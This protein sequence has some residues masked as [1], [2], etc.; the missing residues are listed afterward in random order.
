MPSQKFVSDTVT[1]TSDGRTIVDITKLL[2]KKHMQDMIREMR[3]KTTNV[4]PRRQ[5]KENPKHHT[6]AD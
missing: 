1:V 6:A 4:P 3:A 2:A 5:S